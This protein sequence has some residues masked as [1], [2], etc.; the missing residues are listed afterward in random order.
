MRIIFNVFA[1]LVRKTSGIFYFY[2]S[3]M[4]INLCDLS[5]ILTLITGIPNYLIIFHIGKSMIQ[6]NFMI[7]VKYLI[8]YG[9]QW[10]K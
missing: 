3:L 5:L 10:L 2:S 1:F 6:R 9:L 8:C 7:L 4:Y